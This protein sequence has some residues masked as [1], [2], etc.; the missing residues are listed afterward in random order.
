MIQLN[1]KPQFDYRIRKEQ[2]QRTIGRESLN[3]P[4]ER[5]DQL[6]NPINFL[7]SRA[8]TLFSLAH[9]RPAETSSTV[10]FMRLDYV[11]GERFQILLELDV[12][13]SSLHFPVEAAANAHAASG[14][15]NKL[16]GLICP[17]W[18][19]LQS[20]PSGLDLLLNSIIHSLCCSGQSSEESRY[21]RIQRRQREKSRR[22]GKICAINAKRCK[23]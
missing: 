22:G 9:L 11:S 10:S 2:R 1:G 12:I 7:L 23:Y 19:R 18:I 17:T 13:N 5:M 6:A 8:A 15:N 20:D 3:T 16:R 21:I 4:Q 14:S